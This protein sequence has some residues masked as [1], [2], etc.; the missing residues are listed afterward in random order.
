MRTFH[1]Y[2][3]LT[4]KYRAGWAELDRHEYVTTLRL[5]APKLLSIDD[6]GTKDRIVHGRISAKQREQARKVWEKLPRQGR[7][8]FKQWLCAAVSETFDYGCRCEHDCCGHYQNH[9]MARMYGRN[10]VVAV[11]SYRNI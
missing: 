11:H 9:A 7:A 5:T 8:P 10:V 1:I 2:A 6:D 4:H 3:R